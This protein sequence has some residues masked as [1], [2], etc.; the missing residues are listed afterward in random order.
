MKR[1]TDD[2]AAQDLRSVIEN[3]TNPDIGYERYVK[4][5]DYELTGYEPD[6]IGRLINPDVLYKEIL[7]YKCKLCHYRGFDKCHNLDNC[8]VSD[9]LGRIDGKRWFKE[10]EITRRRFTQIEREQ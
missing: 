10:S 4:L 2:K 9:L 7:D 3:S 5:A 1:L 8:V 6:E